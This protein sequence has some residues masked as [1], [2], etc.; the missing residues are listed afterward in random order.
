MLLFAALSAREGPHQSPL[1]ALHQTTLAVIT[2]RYYQK[3][4]LSFKSFHLS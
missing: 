2:K 4:L 3:L 1:A